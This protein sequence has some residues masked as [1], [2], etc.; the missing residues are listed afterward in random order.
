MGW[1]LIERMARMLYLVHPSRS[2]FRHIE[3]VPEYVQEAVPLVVTIVFAEVIARYL[4]GRPARVNQVFSSFGIGILHESAGLVTAS[5]G[6]ASYQML[7]QYRLWELPWDSP[8]TWFGAFIFVD[9][10]Y[11]WI[12]RANHEL[13]VLWAIHQVHHSSEDFDFATA[14][15][16]SM[17]QR[18]ANM[19]CY[20]PLALLGFPLPSV[21]VHIALNYVFQIWV[22][23]EY[24]G[25]LGPIGWIFMTPSHH[26]VHHGANKW[27]LDKNYAS[28]LIIWDRIFGTFEG[29]RDQEE[30]VYGLTQQPQTHNVLW[31]QFFYFAEVYRKARS[32]SS[33]GDSLRS[34]F[35]G[36]G[37]APGTPRLGDPLTFTDVQA[38]RPKYDPQLPL[39]KFMYVSTHMALSFIA[40]QLMCFN[41]QIL[42]L[43]AVV[44]SQIFIFVTVGV[45]SAMYDGWLWAPVVEAV[46][47]A[48]VIAYSSTTSITAIPDVDTALLLYFTASLTLWISKA[49]TIVLGTNL[50][51]KTM[52]NIPKL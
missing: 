29:E 28:V 46:R 4:M 45:M 25:S 51:N 47:C 11:Y 30:I 23:T 15:R 34:V 37:W 1:F 33:W 44:T 32:M 50:T 48:A 49:L 19:C 52:Q 22:H 39:W 40:Q 17:F 26:R 18:P 3:E 27:C 6:V 16:I 5:F 21:V 10:C 42:S 43:E 14:T 24:I 8:Y 38:P 31:H 36:P 13:N 35:Y 2:T 20:Q 41:F 9:F 12:H 7:Y